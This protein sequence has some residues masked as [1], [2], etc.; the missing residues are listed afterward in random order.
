MCVEI[1]CLEAK[2]QG[3]LLKVFGGFYSSKMHYAMKANGTL[4]E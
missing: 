1:L 2:P 4:Y 3:T